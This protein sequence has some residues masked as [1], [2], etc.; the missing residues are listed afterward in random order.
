MKKKIV[1]ADGVDKVIAYGI[2]GLFI[3]LLLSSIS[4]W[5]YDLSIFDGEDME[6]VIKYMAYGLYFFSITLL[7]SGQS[8]GKKI[9]GLKVVNKD[10][11]PLTFWNLTKREV[12]FSHMLYVFTLGMFFIVDVLVGTFREDGQCLH[13]LLSN[14]MVVKDS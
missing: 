9:M 5:G 8:I 12:I 6:T 10:G 4:Y 11:T 7:V 2:D 1:A 14:T 3:A 13:D